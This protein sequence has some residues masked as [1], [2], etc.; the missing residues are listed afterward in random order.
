MKNLDL[1]TLGK[2]F[3]ERRRG[4]NLSNAIIRLTAEPFS[5]GYGDVVSMPLPVFFNYLESANS[6]DKQMK[7]NSKGRK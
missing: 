2:Q 5:N 6:Y 7:K 1:K 4:K 3:V